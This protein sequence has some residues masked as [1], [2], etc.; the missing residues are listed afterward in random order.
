MCLYS[1]QLKP[2]KAKTDITVYKV[3]YLK[4][5]NTPTLVNVGED[6]L[7]I[8]KLSLVSKRGFEYKLGGKKYNSVKKI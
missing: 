1:K 8:Q 4:P 6:L 3:V 5:I 7:R 2:L